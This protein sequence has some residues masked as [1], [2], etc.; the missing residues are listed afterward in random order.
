MDLEKIGRFIKSKRLSKGLT[1]EELADKLKVSNKSVSK[2]ENGNGLMDI[3]LLEP[4]SKILDINVI[5]ILNGEVVNQEKNDILEDEMKK[6]YLTIRKKQ[7][8]KLFIYI[9]FTIAILFVLGLFFYLKSNYLLEFR[10]DVNSTTDSTENT[11]KL[12]IKKNYTFNNQGLVIGNLYMDN[13][14]EDF[15]LKKEKFLINQDL[16][17]IYKYY[18]YDE[19]NDLMDSMWIT[20][21]TYYNYIDFL[22]N[23]FY[24]PNGK[25][26]ISKKQ[27]KKILNKNNINNDVSLLRFISKYHPKKDNVFTNKQTIKEHYLLNYLKLQFNHNFTFIYGDYYGFVM[28]YFKDG[29]KA[30]D[31]SI[32][33]KDKRYSFTFIGDKFTN[34]KFIRSF[35]ENLDI[36]EEAIND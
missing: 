29:L 34:V 5:D 22:N 15:V 6:M 35:L 25:Y 36:R 12:I 30:C 27:I 23:D 33:Q 10:I 14:V 1:Q 28:W 32:Y 3:S 2:W 16:I 24:S 17:T 7:K 8:R 31:M 20:D 19:N 21:K 4:L 26:K 11:E 9:I 18:L 13:N